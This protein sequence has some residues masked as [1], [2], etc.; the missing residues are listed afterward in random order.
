MSQDT[1]ARPWTPAARR[2]A[3]VAFALVLVLLLAW[4]WWLG[5]RQTEYDRLSY[6]A[7][8]P[9]LLA[10]GRI[11]ALWAAVL[12]LAQYALS[13]RLRLLDRAL[14]LDRLLRIHAA[15]GATA[16][17]LATAHP[18]LLYATE[19]WDM[20]EITP[21]DVPYLVGAGVLTLAWALVCTAIWREFLELPY[22]WWRRVHLLAFALI[23][24]MAVHGAGAGSDLSEG[25]GRVFWYGLLGAFASLFLWARVARPL[26]ERGRAYTVVEAEQPTPDTVRISLRPTGAAA[27]RHAPGQFAFVS[28]RSRGVSR[29]AH[30]F[31]V[32]TAP[33]DDG[34]L[35]FLMRRSG[36]HTRTLDKIRPGDTASVQGPFGLFSCEAWPWDRLL[37]VAG[38][39]GITPMNSMLNY[40]QDRG[41]TRPVT[42]VWGLRSRAER[43]FLEDVDA[44]RPGFILH[45]V[46]S[47][48]PEAGGNQG[49]VNRALLQRLLTPDDLRARAFVCGPPPMMKSVVRDLRGLGVRPIHT[50]RF[51][52]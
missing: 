49:F 34:T 6:D 17:V 3:T 22:H 28:F 27:M 32:A 11:T 30:P 51:G 48:D 46:Y 9:F 33:A 45:L 18:F 42:L 23:S 39:I 12:F 16:A 25:P 47:D 14:G 8:Q 43:V 36:D 10:A 31:T 44:G 13:A 35:G 26:L 20:P 2:V 7:P 29:E 15:F 41:D 5:L 37:L 40:L 24:L 50:E 38:G 52:F 19:A 1:T 21:Y 4:A